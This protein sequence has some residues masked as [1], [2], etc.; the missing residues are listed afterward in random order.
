[1]TRI[2]RKQSG[3]VRVVSPHCY[4][5]FRWTGFFSRSTVSVVLSPR[6]KFAANLS[7]SRGAARYR[8]LTRLIPLSAGRYLFRFFCFSTVLISG[9]CPRSLSVPE[10]S[11]VGRGLLRAYR[12]GRMEKRSGY[13]STILDTRIC[14]AVCLICACAC[15][16]GNHRR[17]SRQYSI[18]GSNDPWLSKY[19]RV[20]GTFV[21]P[22]PPRISVTRFSVSNKR[23]SVPSF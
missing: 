13:P 10:I 16:N 23:I 8:Y 7:A 20:V 17:L 15:A 6:R 9:L 21:I 2:V 11:D 19:E 18:Y 1:M 3:F 12:K 4:F 22:E 5:L 14:A